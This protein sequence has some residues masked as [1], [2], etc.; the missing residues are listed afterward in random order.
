MRAQVMQPRWA[1][2]THFRLMSLF[3]R[4]GLHRAFDAIRP[5]LVVRAPAPACLPAS[6]WLQ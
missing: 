5:D 4:A 6:L 1:H 3:M 2:L